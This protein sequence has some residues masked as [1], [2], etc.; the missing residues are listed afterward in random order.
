M[1]TGLELLAEID[2]FAERENI[3]GHVK[4]RCG[5]LESMVSI[6]SIIR[7]RNLLELASV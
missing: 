7:M 2:G 1:P 4:R 3:F 6:A 5:P